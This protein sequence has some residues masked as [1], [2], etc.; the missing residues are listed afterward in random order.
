MHSGSV[1]G[2]PAVDTWQNIL[3]YLTLF[4][5]FLM[6][7]FTEKKQALHDIVCKTLVIRDGSCFIWPAFKVILLSILFTILVI[8]GAGVYTYTKYGNILVA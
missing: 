8:A 5:G 1:S 3:S 2:M 4:I 6:A 7:A